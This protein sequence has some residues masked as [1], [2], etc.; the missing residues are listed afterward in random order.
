MKKLEQYNREK[1]A[2]LKLAQNILCNLQPSARLQLA[3][4]L[5][6]SY[7]TLYNYKVGNGANYELALRIIEEGE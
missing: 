7:P 2:A 5:G 4:K 1:K 6:I 3:A